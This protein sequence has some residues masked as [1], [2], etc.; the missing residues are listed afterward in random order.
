[1]NA[2]GF[3]FERKKEYNKEY[4]KTEKY[5][6]YQK[7]DKYK[8]YQKQYQKEYRNMHKEEAKEY[9]K[10]YQKEY[11]KEYDNQLCN[12][13]G[14]TITLGALRKRLKRMGIAH[15]TLEAKKYL[16]NK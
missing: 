10:Q 7:S 15:P 6:E 8:E 9:Q 16:L 14:E 4:K 3:D 11:H 13:N 2:K 5:K 12:Y 1:M